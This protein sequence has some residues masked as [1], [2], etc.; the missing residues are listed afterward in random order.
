M[1]QYLD[2]SQEQQHQNYAVTKRIGPPPALSHI[3]K[4]CELRKKDI[5]DTPSPIKI[6]S[7]V[8]I[9]KEHLI[10]LKCTNPSFRNKRGNYKQFRYAS[11]V[12]V[13]S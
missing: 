4:S 11:N 2:I 9:D 5:D 3:T 12:G 8:K 7:P 6:I 13:K 1:K 10:E